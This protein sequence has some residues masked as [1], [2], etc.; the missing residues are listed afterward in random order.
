MILAILLLSALS[1]QEAEPVALTPDS[2]RRTWSAVQQTQARQWWEGLSDE[3]RAEYIKRQ[4]EWRNMDGQRRQKMEEHRDAFKAQAEEVLA[5]MSATDLEEFGKM[6]E[7]CQRRHLHGLVRSQ[8]RQ[9]GN[10]PPRH[11]PS[12]DISLREPQIREAL[13]QAHASGWLGDK[14][15]IWLETASVDEAMQ[16]LFSIRKW[17]FLEKANTEGFWKANNISEEK[18]G[19]LI[20]MPAEHFLREIKRIMR[21]GHKIWDG[22]SENR[23][24]KGPRQSSEKR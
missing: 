7:H 18:K 9:G 6:D 15:A 10:R 5:S 17:Q 16:V 12:S 22:K 11:S 19:K 24:N 14:A 23:R 13:R 1:Q 3:Q 21:D 20:A 2:A 4:K 8:K